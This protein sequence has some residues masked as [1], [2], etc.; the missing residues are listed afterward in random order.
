M[1]SHSATCNVH[2][3]KRA[4]ED[5]PCVAMRVGL[6]P[7]VSCTGG[8]TRWS[9]AVMC[10]LGRCT[11]GEGRWESMDR[12]FHEDFARSH[13]TTVAWRFKLP[14]R[15]AMKTYGKKINVHTTRMPI[16]AI[17]MFLRSIIANILH[18]KKECKLWRPCFL[19]RIQRLHRSWSAN[20]S[21]Q[22]LKCKVNA[23]TWPGN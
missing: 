23:S 21:M 18:F 11:R 10:L 9:G 1:F 4:Q 13:K 16:E 3:T 19:Q 17:F 12:P 15:N 5:K 20:G 8:W 6:A 2:P 22:R 14:Q 7:S